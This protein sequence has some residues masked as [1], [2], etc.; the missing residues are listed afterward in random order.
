MDADT[1]P[2]LRHL[3]HD[4]YSPVPGKGAKSS[5]H[6]LNRQLLLSL[7]L[8]STSKPRSCQKGPGN[9][10]LSKIS[11]QSPTATME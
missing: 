2:P 8:L 11:T 3:W 9:P 4:L 1:C 5:L 6:T 7:G 10:T